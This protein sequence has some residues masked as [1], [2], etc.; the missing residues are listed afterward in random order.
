M[1]RKLGLLAVFGVLIIAAAATFVWFKVNA[2]RDLEN[3]N[4]AAYTVPPLPPPDPPTSIKPLDPYPDAVRVELYAVEKEWNGKTDRIVRE[5]VRPLAKDQRAAFERNLTIA[6][7]E[8][9]K[10]VAACCFPH[11]FLRYFDVNGKLLGEVGICFCC[12][13]VTSDVGGPLRDNEYREFDYAKMKALIEGLGI[14]TEMG[15]H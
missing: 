10:A 5:W 11:H 6:Y 8:K 15:C 14:P 3:P 13:C 7:Y 1:S 12:R 9:G 2:E 4:L